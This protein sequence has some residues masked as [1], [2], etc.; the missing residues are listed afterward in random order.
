MTNKVVLDAGHGGKD[1]GAVGNGIQ[2]KD[3]TLKVVKLV[4]EFLLKK[5][6][7]IKPVL[8]RGTDSYPSLSERTNM[9]NSIGSDLFLSVHVNAASSTAAN[10]YESFIYQTDDETTKSFALQKLIDKRLAKLWLEKSRKYRGAKKANYHVLRE[11]KGASVLIELGFISN[12][13]DAALLKDDS[14]LEKNAE[15]IA[16]AIAEY[17]GVSESKSTSEKVYRLKVDGKQVAAYSQPGNLLDHVES[18]VNS[19][20]ENIELELIK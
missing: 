5:F 11:Y 6:S 8:T 13:K 9:A 19:G 16:D 2:E 1:P 18:Y 14:F 3:I 4:E 20:T 7:S 17:L 10:G 12:V 15:L